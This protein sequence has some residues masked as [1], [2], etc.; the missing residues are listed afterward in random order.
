MIYKLG[1]S[2]IE[3]YEDSSDYL[4]AKTTKSLIVIRKDKT[5]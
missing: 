3:S 1:I 2:K 4:S 5:N